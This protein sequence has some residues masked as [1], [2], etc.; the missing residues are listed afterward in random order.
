[1]AKMEDIAARFC[2]ICH[3]NIYFLK[4]IMMM[5]MEADIDA[6]IIIADNRERETQLYSQEGKQYK[7]T[8]A[9][10]PPRYSD[11][12]RHYLLRTRPCSGYT[13][14]SKTRA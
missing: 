7:T 12:A 10:F 1:M 14:I 9:S 4:I 5:M 6:S 8:C 13:I 3:V 11:G 2:L